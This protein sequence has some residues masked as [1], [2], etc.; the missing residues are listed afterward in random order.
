MTNLQ[1]IALLSP[2]IGSFVLVI[3]AWLHQNQRISDLRTDSNRHYDEVRSDTN[4]QFDEMRRDTNRQF[5]QMNQKLSTLAGDYRTFYGMEQKL[6]GRVD[7]LSK[8]Q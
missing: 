5:D 2:A 1:F 6:E 4:R 8:R 7:E 3:L